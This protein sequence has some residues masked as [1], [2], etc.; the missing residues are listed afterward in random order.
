MRFVTDMHRDICSI[1]CLGFE[2]NGLNMTLVK[3]T[4]MM[5]EIDVRV[6]SLGQLTSTS[7]NSQVN[8]LISYCRVK[9][10]NARSLS[11]LHA[12]SGMRDWN[13]HDA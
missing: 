9:A 6:L 1:C 4:A 13:F 7:Q 10:F 3:Y 12:G 11:L 5:F 8:Y 2:R